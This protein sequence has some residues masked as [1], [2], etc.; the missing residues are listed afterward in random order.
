MAATRNVPKQMLSA[1]E[2]GRRK[3]P[4][5][6]ASLRRTWMGLLTVCGIA[7]RG[8]FIP[9]R[10]AASTPKTMSYSAL[11]PSF[12]SAEPTFERHLTRCTAYV[13]DF[14]RVGDA[15]PPEPRWRQHWFPGLDAAAAYCFVRARRP[16]RIVEIGSGHS[17]R[18][19]A[20]AVRD[21][22]ISTCLLYTSPSPR[23]LSTSRM[24]SS[25]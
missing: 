22:G 8:Y 25:A 17:T 10:Y 1:R 19:L 5:I 2:N 16:Q 9:Y 20:R 21:E 4:R 14:A 11:E 12:R 7:D 24:P 23:D 13:D 15:A 3:M 6:R 18:F